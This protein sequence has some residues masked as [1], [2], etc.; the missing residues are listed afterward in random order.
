MPFPGGR[1]NLNFF[2]ISRSS[3]A[4][5]FLSPFVRPRF[6]FSSL[7]CL[8][9]ASTPPMDGC[10]PSVFT[11]WPAIAFKDDRFVPAGGFRRA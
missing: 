10:V 2:K 4:V 3:A 1:K 11:T 7:N 6:A 8:A 9:A 5:V